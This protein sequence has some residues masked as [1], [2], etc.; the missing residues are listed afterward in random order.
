MKKITS[1]LLLH[2]FSQTLKEDDLLS[3]QRFR[4]FRLTT[5][6]C[7][8]IF[9]LALYQIFLAHFSRL[10]LTWIMT[11]LFAGIFFN[12]FVLTIH[13]KAKAAYITLLILIFMVL[14][15]VTYA[16][17]GIRNSGMFYLAAVILIAY[18]LLGK[19]GGQIMAGVSIVH[20]VYFYFVSTYTDWV[21]YSI[22]GDGAAMIDLD[23]LITAV[24]SILLL[25]AQATYIEKSKN[26]II[27]DIQLKR[28]ELAIKNAAL[29]NTQKD[30]EIKNKELEQKNKELEQF[31]F[32]SSHD[33]QEPL[34]TISDF[35]GLLRK[36]YVG[37]L[38]EKAD[39]YLAFIAQASDRMKTLIKDLLQYSQIGV[40]KRNEPIN[41]MTVLEEVMVDIGKMI[42]ETKTEIHSGPLPF[43]TGNATGIKQLFQNLIMNA[44]KFR[45]K[46]SIPEIRISAQKKDAYWEF[47]FADNGIG[48]AQQH[49]HRIF[50]I[51]QRLHPRTEYTGSGIGLSHC[52]KIVEL[53]GGK[54]WVDSA[55]G[56]GSTFHFTILV[57]QV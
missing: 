19:K 14:H 29:L 5:L 21:D 39:Q 4:V 15:A 37:K 34:R 44:V 36:R 54:I 35:V 30:L 55:P 3:Q 8:L 11:T 12:Y 46:D 22:I 25:T 18:M 7:L 1:I 24:L 32:I 13:Q 56:A 28:D 42:A 10:L 40:E 49:S 6:F 47:S 51:F 26:A 2:S 16:S 27:N 53:H 33:L 20:V 48:I 45:Q 52:K 57:S 38:D 17:G 50:D 23:Y 43:I 31:A 9:S 41:C